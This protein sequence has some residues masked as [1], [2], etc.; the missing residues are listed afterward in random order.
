MKRCQ[1]APFGVVRRSRGVDDRERVEHDRV[2]EPLDPEPH[3]LEE[4]RRRRSSRWSARRAADVVAGAAVGPP[5]L[6]QPQVVRIVRVRAVRGRRPALD[7]TRPAVG[8]A[9]VAR[10]VGLRPVAARDVGRAHEPGDLG[11]DRGRRVAACAAP[12][13]QLGPRPVADDELGGAAQRA[14]GG[15]VE[16]L[17]LPG[18]HD[19]Q[20]LVVHVVGARPRP[21]ADL[22]VR[23]KAAVPLLR[24]LQQE[25]EPGRGGLRSPRRRSRR[26]RA[27]RGRAAGRGG[28]GSTSSLPAP[29]PGHRR[30]RDRGPRVG[31]VVMRGE[32]QQR[33]LV[34]G[35]APGRPPPGR[36]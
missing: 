4:A 22:D 11:R 31:L 5:A 2:V 6:A 16:P 36:A 29:R 33:R 27:R 12:A 21:A 30:R 26:S 15:D 13:V 24:L 18:E 8:D 9:L 32:H 7:G 20:R 28:R 3:E 34:G 14:P 35:V 25:V 19:R 17:E 10:G 23:R 1:N